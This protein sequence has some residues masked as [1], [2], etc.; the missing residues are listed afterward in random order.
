MS[1]LLACLAAAACGF[2]ADYGTGYRCIDEGDCPDGQ[3]CV[4]NSCQLEVS[5]QE[6]AGELLDGAAPADGPIIASVNLLEDPGFEIGGD[7]NWGKY[8]ST[9]TQTAD[10]PHG[11]GASGHVCEISAAE[12]YT[13]FQPFDADPPKATTYR[14][15]AW[16]RT[17]GETIT[18]KI[19]LREFTD[20]VG[21]VDHHGTDT[22]VAGDWVEL[23]L[24]ATVEDAGRD[25]VQLIVW[26]LDGGAGCFDI[27]DAA[28]YLL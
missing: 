13:V 1:S 16:V 25:G 17:T 6:D 10:E 9:L 3:R 5:A 23:T 2:D 26:G 11:G 14:L 27:D 18:A 21:W 22:L 28:A 20:E 8:N 4:D 24:D 12:A 19:T 7:D 15:S